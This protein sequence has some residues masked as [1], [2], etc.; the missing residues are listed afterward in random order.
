MPSLDCLSALTARQ[1]ESVEN[2]VHI[3]RVITLPGADAFLSNEAEVL[4]DIGAFLGS[5][6]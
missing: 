5:L 4:K 6:H 2:G 3:E 1:E